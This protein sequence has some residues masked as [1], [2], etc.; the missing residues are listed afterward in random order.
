MDEFF[1][2]LSSNS[3]VMIVI[4]VLLIILIAAYVLIYLM[5]FFQGR[6][7]SFWPP[8]VGKRPARPVLEG[9]KKDNHEGIVNKEG[10]TREAR[11]MYEHTGIISIYDNLEACKKDMQI[12][13][14]KARDIRLLLQ[15]GQAELGGGKTSLLYNLVLEKD[16]PGVRVRI[17]RAS[18]DSPFLSE[19]RAKFRQ[20][21]PA[22]YWQRDL[23]SLDDKINRIRE[24]NRKIEIEERRHKE[25]FLW[26]IFIFD[27]IAYVSAYLYRRGNDDQATVYKIQ[28][29]ANEQDGRSLFTIFSKYFDYLWKKWD[30]TI[31]NEVE[32]WM[33]W[34]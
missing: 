31:E 3:G 8:K 22:I 4:I 34:E 29:G 10:N 24:M 16:Q 25:P 14:Q 12:D 15:I 26:R 30:P 11:Y 23:E 32:K 1:K 27:D 17:L 9:V 20:G 28:R 2:L 5:A 13:I 21:T 33:N 7:I 19:K 6:D 18:K